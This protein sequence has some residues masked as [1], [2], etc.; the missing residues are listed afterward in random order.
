ME[1]DLNSGSCGSPGVRFDS[2]APVFNLLLI[3]SDLLSACPLLLQKF[4]KAERSQE[5]QRTTI[6]KISLQYMRSF[7][8]CSKY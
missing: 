5:T 6:H 7:P 2:K 1:T 4:L 3:S 8:V